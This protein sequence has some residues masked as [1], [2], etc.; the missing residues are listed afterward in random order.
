MIYEDNNSWGGT[1]VGGSIVRGDNSGGDKSRGTKSLYKL[2]SVDS[3]GKSSEKFF[4]KC[5]LKY[6][7]KLDQVERNAFSC[8][9]K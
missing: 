9:V 4:S 8:F 2:V 5:G 3:N 6:R 7:L 1:I